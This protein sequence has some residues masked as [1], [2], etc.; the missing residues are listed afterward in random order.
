MQCRCRS[1]RPARAW[2]RPDASEPI[3]AA[4]GRGKHPS[5]RRAVLPWRRATRPAPAQGH[6][7]P[8][9]W[10]ERGLRTGSGPAPCTMPSRRRGQAQPL[11]R[12]VPAKPMRRRRRRQRDADHGHWHHARPRPTGWPTRPTA[13]GLSANA[14][15]FV[16]RAGVAQGAIVADSAV[17]RAGERNARRSRTILAQQVVRWPIGLQFCSCVWLSPR[18]VPARRR[19]RRRARR[20]QPAS[21]RR[22]IG[23]I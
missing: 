23:T 20:H 1:S 3:W 8:A 17:P 21:S 9:G 12:L 13:P 14:A 15:E 22:C 18:A 16:G 5:A 6:P 4:R 19:R 10:P 7:G 2:L 11:A